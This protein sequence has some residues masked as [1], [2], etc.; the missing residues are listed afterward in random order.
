MD[1][2]NAVL[3]ELSEARESLALRE[4]EKRRA[5]R[6]LQDE[7]HIKRQFLAKICSLDEARESGK[8]EATRIFQSLF[9]L[10]QETDT[11]SAQ[12]VKSLKE[13]FSG[14]IYTRAA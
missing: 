14:H 8:R 1:E 13:L 3:G 2:I 4:E 7:L 6:E 11:F 12:Q 10:W 9:K 5:Q